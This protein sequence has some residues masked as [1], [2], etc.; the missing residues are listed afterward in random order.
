MLL[1]SLSVG[2]CV[3]SI[4]A[5]KVWLG[6]VELA[7]SI[8]DSVTSAVSREDEI[9]ETPGGCSG[10]GCSGFVSVENALGLS[11]FG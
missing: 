10:F 4:V 2:Y 1:C 11:I 7:L 8:T 3:R 9:V 6:A 5:S